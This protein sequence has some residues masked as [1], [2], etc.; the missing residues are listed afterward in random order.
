MGAAVL[1]I[2]SLCGV[3]FVV[4]LMLLYMCGLFDERSL[5]RGAAITAFIT[6]LYIDQASIYFSDPRPPCIQKR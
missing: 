6:G 2:F 5:S 4:L 3:Y 1:Q